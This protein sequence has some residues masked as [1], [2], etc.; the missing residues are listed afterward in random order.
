VAIYKGDLTLSLREFPENSFDWAL[1]VNVLYALENP[2]RCL[3]EVFRVLQPDSVLALSTSHRE[4]NVRALFDAIRSDLES[5]GLLESLRSVVEDAEDRHTEMMSSI[6]RDTRD[7]VLRYL[8]TAGFEI[9]S[10]VDSA[11]AGSV[12]IVH[13]RK[14][15]PRKVPD[16][17]RPATDVLRKRAVRDQIFISYCHRD[18]EWQRRLQTF[19]TPA[20]RSGRL[21]LWDDTNIQMGS[22]WRAEIQAAIDRARVAILLVSP[23]FLNS[24][25]IVE[26]E[27]PEILKAAREHGLRIVWTL[28]SRAPYR[29]VG[30]GQVLDEI[31]CAH[32]VDTPLDMLDE[33]ERNRFFT[34]F[35][36]KLAALCPPEDTVQT[37]AAARDSG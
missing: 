11:Y 21:K 36:H 23:E 20:F 8:Q 2:E 10:T 29:M 12:M 26:S 18:R 15:L 19:L 27:F 16:P 35:V 28:L 17:N 32:P 24:K 13:A 22:E 14:P 5:Q 31:Q 3:T 25:F 30:L 4:T 33:P 37:P 34:Q 7:D 9:V 6:H 1:M